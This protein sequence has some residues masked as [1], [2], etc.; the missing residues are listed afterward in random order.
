MAHMFP[1]RPE[2]PNANDNNS[3]IPVFNP[4]PADCGPA[5]PPN[6][7]AVETAHDDTPSEAPATAPA[8]EKTGKSKRGRPPKEPIKAEK[9]ARKRTVEKEVTTIHFATATLHRL[10]IMHVMN[11]VSLSDIVSDCCDDML[12]RSYQCHEPSCN[13]KFTICSNGEDAAPK[14]VCCPS[15]GSD[16]LR[17]LKPGY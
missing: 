15:C 4:I 3:D 1:K 16:N 10:R 9:S 11:K 2:N 7:N 12:N 5:D 8:A 17:Q 6:S 13:C 14:P